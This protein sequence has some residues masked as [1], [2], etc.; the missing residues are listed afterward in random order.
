MV[1]PGPAWRVLAAIG[2]GGGGVGR[3]PPPGEWS[4]VK[5]VHLAGTELFS[6]NQPLRDALALPGRKRVV[7]VLRRFRPEFQL[8]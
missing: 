6:K 2:W 1:S 4:A 8:P 7:S 3:D 5:W